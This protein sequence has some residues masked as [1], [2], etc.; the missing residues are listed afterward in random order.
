MCMFLFTLVLYTKNLRRSLLSLLNA[1]FPLYTYIYK[2]LDK[3][4]RMHADTQ[5]MTSN[6]LKQNKMKFSNCVKSITTE[7]DTTN[8]ISFNLF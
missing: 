6:R 1:C 7:A 8:G 3:T 4:H 2:Y 5:I